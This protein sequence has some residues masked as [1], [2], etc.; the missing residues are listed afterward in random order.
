MVEQELWEAYENLRQDL[1]DLKDCDAAEFYNR[2]DG[3]LTVGQ[4]RL[5]YEM[6]RNKL[7]EELND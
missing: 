1:H 3:S 2:E 5:I 7:K 4:L 6:M